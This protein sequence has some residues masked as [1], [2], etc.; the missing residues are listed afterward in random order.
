MA[1]KDSTDGGVAEQATSGERRRLDP[2]STGFLPYVKRTIE[3]Q[4]KVF[5]GQ[6]LGQFGLVTFLFFMFVGIFGPMFAPH[7]PDDVMRNAQG[8]VVRWAAPSSEYLLGTTQYG[9]DVFSQ[10]V[11]G[12]QMSLLVGFAAAVIAVVMGTLI[13]LLSGYYGGALDAV[14]M[15]ITDI[16]YGI[17]F[18]P[19]LVVLVIILEPGLYMI[20]AGISALL[21]RSSARVI[22]SQ[23]LTIKE[24][25]YIEAAH[26]IGISDR[27][28][29]LRHLL[30]NVLPLAFL[31]V[32]FSVNIA[33]LAEASL[34]F[35]GFGDPNSVS[36]G[37]MMFQAYKAGALRNGWWWIVFPGLM[38]SLIVIAV[39]AISRT[40]EQVTNPELEAEG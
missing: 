14:F 6:P 16:A 26:A 5:R 20:I 24:R 23:V 7:G 30:P 40:Y 10:L 21:W 11:L 33:I 38:L 27:R 19:F 2:E 31:Y 36:W 37:T 12:T 28:L 13:G 15:R 25:P 17:P 9:R 1:Q 8:D 39:F 4:R 3:N 34:A 29:I 18:L 32:A 22:R 35:L